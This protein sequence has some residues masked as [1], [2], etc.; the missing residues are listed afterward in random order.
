VGQVAA[1]M[2]GAGGGELE[3]GGRGGGGISDACGDQSPA[4]ARGGRT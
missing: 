2:R 4:E 3:E 1:V